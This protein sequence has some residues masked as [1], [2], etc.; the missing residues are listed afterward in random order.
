MSEDRSYEL[1]S[2]L[3]PTTSLGFSTVWYH[4]WGLSWYLVVLSHRS[5]SRG[6]VLPCG[7]LILLGW[8]YEGCRSRPLD[9]SCR[10]CAEVSSERSHSELKVVLHVIRH[11]VRCLTRTSHFPS[12]NSF[13][14]ASFLCCLYIVLQFY[15]HWNPFHIFDTV[16][17]FSHKKKK[18]C[19]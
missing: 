15:S 4:H 16:L 19:W 7:A 6:E 9:E 13:L 10:L 3:L 11:G 2:W 5:L 14:S 17:I 1:R 12:S 18:D 8:E